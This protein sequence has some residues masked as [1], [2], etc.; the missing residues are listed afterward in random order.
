M[1]ISA[2]EAQAPHP[3]IRRRLML[4][5]VPGLMAFSMGQTVLFAIAGP[6]FREIGLGEAQ[7]GIMI[8]SAA[9]V[10]MLASTVW[11]AVS[12]RWGR[13]VS[14]VCGLAT[15][16]ALSVVFALVMNA[17]LDGVLDSGRVFITLV[18]LRLLIAA[19]GA[20]IQP[21]AVALMAD[22]S[23][24]E[25]RSSAVATVG[26][27]FGLGMILGPASASLLVGIDVLM[28]LYFVAA[29]GLAGSVVAIT[30][31]PRHV[32]R[33]PATAEG[34][35]TLPLAAL[36]PLIASMTLLY[37][38]MSVVQ[39]TLAFNV[40]DILGTDSVATARLAGFLFLAVAVGM[41]AMQGG[42]IQFLKP[43]PRVLLMLG[44]PAIL[45]GHICY[46][47]ADS[48]ALLVLALATMGVGFGLSSPA[49]SAAASILTGVDAQGR[50][51][52]VM[53]AAMAGGFVVGPILGTTLYEIERGYAAQLALVVA[54]AASVLLA[55][56]LLLRGA[57]LGAPREEAPSIN[58][59]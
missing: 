13:K 19:F 36:S 7:L 23:S 48:Y 17:G 49:I 6:V 12:D 41:L 4:G 33:P 37:L 14:I 8:S 25:E 16:G 38:G 24:H 11:G 45:L 29:L 32:A 30:V 21:A 28:P 18:V 3:S 39:Q 35:G 55:G 47:F 34:R 22:S 42:V 9:V 51:A 57:A 5:I 43:S 44:V 50:I 31:L 40:Q 59:G 20:G 58:N 15:Y 10:L 2:T 56:W 27:A 53:Q 54:I 1:E 46:A 52:G 26:A